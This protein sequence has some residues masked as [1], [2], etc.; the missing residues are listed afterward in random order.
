MSYAHRYH[1]QYGLIQFLLMEV[2]AT[3]SEKTRPFHECGGG[4]CLS[5]VEFTLRAGKRS[6]SFRQE[7]TWKL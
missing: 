6:G 2:F 3:V 4:C 1:Y 7:P 5:L